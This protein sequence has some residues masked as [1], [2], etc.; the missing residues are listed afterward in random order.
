MA[1][2]RLYLERRV[3][4]K[5]KM[6]RVGGGKPRDAIT[7]LSHQSHVWVVRRVALSPS[8]AIPAPDKR[9]PP[10]VMDSEPLANP[11]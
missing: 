8:A 5:E 9:M 4:H 6:A 1:W 10:H 11:S 3:A 2:T 7:Q